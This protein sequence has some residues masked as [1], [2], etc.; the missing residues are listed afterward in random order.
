VSTKKITNISIILKPSSFDDLPNMITNLVR[1]LIKRKKN[2][3]FLDSEFERFNALIAPKT[4]K[5][6]NFKDKETVY[7]NS[8]LIISLGGDG[9]LIGVCRQTNPKIPIFGVNLGRLGFI[10]EFNKNDFY[11]KLS[12]VLNNK[13]ETTRKQLYNLEI[14]RNNQLRD[15]GIFFND[16]VFNKNDIARMFTL[17]LEASDEHV[18]NLTGDG[19]IISSTVGST[20]YSLAAGGPIVH[21]DVKAFILTPI[22]PHSLTHRPLVIPDSNQLKIQLIE[23]VQSV[24]ITLDGQQAIPVNKDD[25]IIIK[26]LTRKTVSLIKNFDRT[27]FHTLKEKLVHGRRDA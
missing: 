5:L 12:E 25:L 7:Q 9:T 22:C 24:T 4:L 2:V 6:F 27:Y 13:F 8:D 10:T 20:A 3:T 1:W 23:N 18:F 11:E 17:C 14:Y 21:P 26:K 19:L 15:S 16:A